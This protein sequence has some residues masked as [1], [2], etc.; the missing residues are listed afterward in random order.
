MSSPKIEKADGV[1][2]IQPIYPAKEKLTSRAI[3]KVMKTALDEIHQIDETLS[4]EIMQKYG[5][6]SLDKAIRDSTPSAF[7]IFGELMEAV[8]KLLPIFPYKK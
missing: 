7:S 6:I 2:A 3:S 5:L 1:L 4:D 8:R